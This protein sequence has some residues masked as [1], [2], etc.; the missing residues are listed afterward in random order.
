MELIKSVQ[1]RMKAKPLLDRIAQSY[2]AHVEGEETMLGKKV[3]LIVIYTD[4]DVWQFMEECYQIL[5][6]VM[7]KF[8]NS[9]ADVSHLSVHQMRPHI[10]TSRRA[11]ELEAIDAFMRR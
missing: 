5:H 3:A 8:T 2:L 9:K 10:S 4:I 1:A 11:D 7:A 6:P